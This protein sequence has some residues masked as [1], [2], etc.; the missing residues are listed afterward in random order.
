MRFATQQIQVPYLNALPAA[1][2]APACGY[3]IIIPAVQKCTTP[4]TEFQQQARMEFVV[5]HGC[6]TGYVFYNFQSAL[7]IQE[8]GEVG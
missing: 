3:I 6:A 1:L 5:V 4:S 7:K 8:T 2:L